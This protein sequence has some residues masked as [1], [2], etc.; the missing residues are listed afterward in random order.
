M[1][2]DYWT[3]KEQ[4]AKLVE[5]SMLS[6]HKLYTEEKRKREE[7]ETKYNK[8]VQKIKEEGIARAN[9]KQVAECDKYLTSYALMW[10]RL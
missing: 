9:M 1:S 7:I 3:R 8:L 6:W 2:E 5:N 10:K 4:Y